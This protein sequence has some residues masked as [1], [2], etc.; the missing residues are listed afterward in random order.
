M[1][2][3]KVAGSS[4]AVAPV[5]ALSST[6][7]TNAVSPSA[8]GILAVALAPVAASRRTLVA[9]CRA[10]VEAAPVATSTQEKTTNPMNLV[11][12]ATE[13]APW[14]KTGESVNA[15]DFFDGRDLTHAHSLSPPGGLGD[16]IGGGSTHSRWLTPAI[17]GRATLLRRAPRRARQARPQRHLDRAEVS[18]ASPSP[19]AHNA[20]TS[21]RHHR[22]DQ[23]ADGWDTSVTINIDG[24]EVRFFHAVKKGVHR[25]FVDHPWFLAKV[26]LRVVLHRGWVQNLRLWHPHQVWGK[27]G[28]KLYGPKSGADYVDNHKRFA[29]FNK[30]AIEAMKTLPFGFGENCVFVANDWHSALLPVMLKDVYQ[31]KGQFMK[32]KVALCIHNIAFQVG[33]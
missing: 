2:Q 6:H 10:T 9:P 8:R 33:A 30:A 26:R 13:V 28:A 24:Q 27:T 4:R 5:Q 20:H 14:S 29:L 19:V 11:F 16:V 17:H 3:Q 25:V 7:S 32:T 18:R 1:Q 12:V 31:A 22:Y 21:F 15:V 23:Y